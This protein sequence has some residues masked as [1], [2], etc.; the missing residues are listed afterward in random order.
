MTML[1]HPCS[2]FNRLRV[3]SFPCSIDSVPPQPPNETPTTDR[4]AQGAITRCPCS[5]LGFA[6]TRAGSW[7]PSEA[8]GG[9]R[10]CGRRAATGKLAAVS[11]RARAS[12]VHIHA[13]VRVD[14][15]LQAFPSLLDHAVVKVPGEALS[16]KR[17]HVHAR[18]LPLQLVA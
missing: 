6:E 15:A 17:R 1:A 4:A 8:A 11:N 3:P 9:P 5:T 18:V 2:V 7:S 10:R 16:W 13:N 12:P 14:E